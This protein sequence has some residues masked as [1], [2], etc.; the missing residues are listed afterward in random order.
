MIIIKTQMNE[1][2]VKELCNNIIKIKPI[3][4]YAPCGLNDY[5]CP[6]CNKK[7]EDI[8]SKSLQQLD[9]INLNNLKHEKNCAF[10]IT[11]KL[12]DRNNL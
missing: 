3:E 12:I 8:N 9:N 7:Q 1:K 5:Y 11:M 2:L 10:I 4:H 6:L